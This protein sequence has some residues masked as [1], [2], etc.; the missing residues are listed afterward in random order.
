MADIGAVGA[1]PRNADRSRFGRIILVLASLVLAG[2]TTTLEGTYGPPQTVA[3]AANPAPVDPVQA[4][5][6]AE[7]HPRIVA[8]FGG[9]YHDD[10]LEKTLARIV[11]RAVA[12]SDDPSQSYRITILNSP[13]VN[14][15]AL[16]GGYLYVTRGLLA[17]ANDSSEVA[18]VISHEMGHVTANHAMQR[19]E[20]ARA[21]MIVS[22]VVTD[23]LQNDDAGQ[24]ALASSQRTLAAFSQQQE[25]EADAIGVR[26]IGK[27][28]YDP[29]AAARFLDQMG[30]YAAYKSAGT[31][32]DKQPDFLATHPATPQRVEFAVRAARQFGAP[33]IGEVDRDR[34][35]MG[36]DGIVYGDD[37]S[38]GFVRGK[39]FLHP[40]LGVGFAVPDG[41]VLDNTSDAVLATGPDGTALR[42]DGAN[43]P[44][45]TSLTDYLASGW[46]NGLDKASIRTFTVNGLEAVSARAQAKGWVF[47]I[48]VIRAGDAATY[49]F[50]F[51]N[52]SDTPGLEKATAATVQSFRKLTPQEA[53]SLQPLRIRIVTVQPGDTVDTM[54]A[55][56]QGV[57]RPRDLFLVLNDIKPG[58]GLPAIGEKVKIVHD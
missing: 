38:Q 58:A 12:A 49:R 22:R 56:M 40:S 54:A 16:P 48:A 33:G 11:G 28:G 8:N 39:L 23:V 55:R 51:A 25:L 10:K 27:A 53:A 4:K 29:F 43:L 13:S 21:A 24:L 9:V 32:Q 6:G 47:R 41:F 3:G 57:D 50:I 37:P 30:R 7:E 52:E 1:V 44:P 2:C 34:Y 42:F 15:F 5:I 45:G 36:I 17:L 19:Q 46:V 35:L 26:T 18:A 14:A 31:L 20:K